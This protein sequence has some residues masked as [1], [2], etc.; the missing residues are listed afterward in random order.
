[1]EVPVFLTHREYSVTILTRT[2]V[3]LAL[4]GNLEIFI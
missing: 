4:S 1:M 3:F 2:E